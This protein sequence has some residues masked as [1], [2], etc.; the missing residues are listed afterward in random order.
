[1]LNLPAE[2]IKTENSFLSLF[3]FTIFFIEWFYHPIIYRSHRIRNTLLDFFTH[4][5]CVHC[6]ISAQMTHFYFTQH[7]LTTNKVHLRSFPQHRKEYYGIMIGEKCLIDF[8]KNIWRSVSQ[9]L[10]KNMV[11]LLIKYHVVGKVV[12][13]HLRCV[14]SRE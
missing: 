12:N 14:S 7:L 10:E 11:K 3:Y 4:F 1:M 13:I 9:K 5:F 2:N 6:I 8:I